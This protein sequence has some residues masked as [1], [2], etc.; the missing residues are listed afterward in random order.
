MTF[1]RINNGVCTIIDN[2]IFLLIKH[3]I[4]PYCTI[5]VCVSILWLLFTPSILCAYSLSRVLPKFKCCWPDKTPLP[6]YK[7]KSET[8]P[9]KF[10]TN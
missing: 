3:I 9:I 7:T 2:I 8:K 10:E 6:E 1:D 4:E 5:D